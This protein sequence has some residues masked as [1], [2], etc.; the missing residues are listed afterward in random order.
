M[1]R[2]K[3]DEGLGI[4]DIGDRKKGMPSQ[5]GMEIYKGELQ[6]GSSDAKKNRTTNRKKEKSEI[7]IAQIPF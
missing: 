2:I 7:K 5:I 6:M 1:K 4:K 3:E